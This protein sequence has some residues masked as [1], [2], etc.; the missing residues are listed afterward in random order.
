MNK[1]KTDIEGVE[2]IVLAAVLG[3]TNLGMERPAKEEVTRLLS[4]K[5]SWRP[6]EIEG[7]T[8]ALWQSYMESEEI[9]SSFFEEAKW[10]L[11]DVIPGKGKGE[12]V[13]TK[14]KVKRVWPDIAELMGW[15]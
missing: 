10:W 15:A 1:K 7:A 11:N 9:Q 6:L 4:G 8:M 13:I 14:A 3:G 2:L 12:E 5:S